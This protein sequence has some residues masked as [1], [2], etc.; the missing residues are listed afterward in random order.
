MTPKR[1]SDLVAERLKEA[2]QRRSWTAEDL[3]ARCAEI[4]APEI[5][6]SV[7][8]NIETGRRDERGRRRRAVTVEE[9]LSLAYALEVPPVLLLSPLGGDE[10]LEVAAGVD[11]GALDAAAWI[12]DDD[13]IL[14]LGREA[15]VL[16]ED[17]EFISRRQQ[18]R[19]RAPL[20]LVR[21]IRVLARAI[22]IRDRRL[23]S[24]V[25]RQRYEG[26]LKEDETALTIYGMRLRHLEEWL[27]SLGYPPP[28]V[29]DVDEI[30]QRRDVPIV[31]LLADSLG[32]APA[33]DVY[34]P[35]IDALQENEVPGDGPRT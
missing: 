17:S 1:A 21:L 10:T 2:R 24:E 9:L 22:R 18:D 6:R 26:S 34:D 27:A 19:V 30:L 11:L 25:Y 13:A 32:E 20:T 7:I 33:E 35:A 3:A 5:T 28:A 16:G 29:P 15:I 31:P 8:A 23:S 12:A 4:G 14:G